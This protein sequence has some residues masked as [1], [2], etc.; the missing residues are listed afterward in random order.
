MTSLVNLGALS[1][2]GGDLSRNQDW[3]EFVLLF[4]VERKA[5]ASDES[6]KE[7]ELR[8]VG[9]RVCMTYVSV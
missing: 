2:G 6:G 9:L 7:L 4:I 5:L 3:C 8:L 1:F